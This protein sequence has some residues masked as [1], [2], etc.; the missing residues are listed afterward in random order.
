MPYR[1]LAIAVVERIRRCIC[2]LN[3]R[4]SRPHHALA[5][6]VVP[7]VEASDFQATNMCPFAYQC[8][9]GGR[10]VASKAGE[11][12]CKSL[13]AAGGTPRKERWV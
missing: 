7:R 8:V 10:A 4:C 3:S 1:A 12:K 11:Q 6:T 13:H 2:T 9:G 5:L